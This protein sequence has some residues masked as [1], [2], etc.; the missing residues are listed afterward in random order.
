MSLI[1]LELKKA[2]KNKNADLVEYRK[3]LQLKDRELAISKSDYETLVAKNRSLE[4]AN[5]VIFLGYL[6]AFMKSQKQHN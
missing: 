2:L 1:V 3:T 6:L 4:E 5:K